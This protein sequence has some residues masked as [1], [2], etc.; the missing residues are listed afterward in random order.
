MKNYVATFTRAHDHEDGVEGT[1][2]PE[3][4]V[5]GDKSE[6]EAVEN[7]PK[8]RRRCTESKV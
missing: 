6:D 8:S 1:K 4:D 2:T 5:H 3:G 7:D